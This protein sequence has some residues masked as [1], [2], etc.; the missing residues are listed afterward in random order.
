M[1]SFDPLRAYLEARA[2]FTATELH[3]LEG[4]F[5]PKTLR[6]R[7]FLQ[8]AGEP[9][10][11]AAFVSTGCLRSYVVD[12]NGGEVILEFALPNWWL[13][14][15]TFLTG[16]ATCECFIDA[17]RHSDLLL[18]DRASHQKMIEHSPVFAAMYRVAFQKYAAAKDRRI[19]G[20]L[21]MTAEDRYLEFLKKSPDI[22]RQVPQRMMASY[23]GISPETLSRIRKHRSSS[24]AG[25]SVL[26]A[27]PR[28]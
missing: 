26:K 6:P 18:F 3:F 8:R 16:G 28:S 12:S 17:V 22:A 2:P 20:A 23:L 27:K 9:V 21:S 14:D 15:H 24:G 25:S 10:R 1:S 7:E 4:L 13:G 5:I 19:I 11:Y